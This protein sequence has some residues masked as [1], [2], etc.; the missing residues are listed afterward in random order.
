MLRRPSIPLSP[1]DRAVCVKWSCRMLG[2][3]A[4]IVTATLTLPIF[5]GEPANVSRERTQ[6]Q[7]AVRLEFPSGSVNHV[8]GDPAVKQW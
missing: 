1:E 2:I 6:D 5:R 4:A 7:A 8:T 3:W